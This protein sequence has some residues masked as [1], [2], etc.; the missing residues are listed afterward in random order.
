MGE[1]R[2][3]KDDYVNNIF[4]GATLCG[5]VQEEKNEENPEEWLGDSGASFHITHKK[6][7]MIDVEKID[8]NVTVGNSQKLKCELKVS[9]NMKLQD[10]Q[11][12]K[13]AKLL[14]LPQSMKNLLRV[15]RLVSK[16]TNMGST[17]DEMIIK[18]YLV[19]MKLDAR[20]GQNKYMIF[21]FKVNR[22]AL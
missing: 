7:D 15:S 10:V 22:Y 5:E 2:K 16:G 14:Y 21:Y 3:D 13:L 12:V 17:Q 20:K 4:V 8:I 19:I 11:T 1:E 9:V 6:K 18:K